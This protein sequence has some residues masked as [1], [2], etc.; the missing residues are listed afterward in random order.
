MSWA[1][2]FFSFSGRISRV[3]YWLFFA[4]YLISLLILGGIATLLF[5]NPA[6]AAAI[7]YAIVALAWLFVMLIGSLAVGVKRLHDRDKSGWWLVLFYLVPALFSAAGRAA[8]EV[9]NLEGQLV[10]GLIAFAIGIWA[11]VELGILAGTRGPNRYGT[12]PVDRRQE[13]EDR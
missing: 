2:L 3:K 4:V 11:L 8:G 7:L 10:C 1:D 13:T 9:G 12:D 5:P 6:P